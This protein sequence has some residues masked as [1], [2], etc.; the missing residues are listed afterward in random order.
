MPP[1][2]APQPGHD[3]FWRAW[4]AV[5]HDRQYTQTGIPLPIGFLVI[6]AYATRMG[7]NGQSF[8]TL[9]TLLRVLDDEWRAFVAEKR[10]QQE[11]SRNS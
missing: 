4:E 1:E 9:L 11:Q 2:A 5:Q 8:E 7:I 3:M 6:D 10:A